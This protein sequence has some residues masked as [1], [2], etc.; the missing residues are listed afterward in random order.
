VTIPE[1]G[2]TEQEVAALVQLPDPELQVAFSS[3]LTGARELILMDALL[4]TVSELDIARLDQELKEF[5]PDRALSMLAGRG[6]RG[7]LMFA[8]PYVLAA[9]PHLLGYY[10]LLLGYSQKEFYTSRTGA[11]RFKGM[12]ERGQLSKVHER[13]LKDL[14]SALVHGAVWLLD[15]VGATPLSRERLDH[16][17]LL[18]L[19]PQLRGGSNVAKGIRAIDE[20]FSLIKEITKAASPIISAR[21]IEL[22]NDSKL[23]ILIEFAADPDIVVRGELSP[24]N[25]ENILAIEVKGGGDF[26]NIHNRIGEAEKC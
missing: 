7:E 5:V 16:L 1:D 19:G 6:L 4:K 12:E 14:C 2:L 17:T 10:R 9:N 23:K 18:T 20:V 22:I 25:F 24:G 15:G 3:A 26:S 8:T 11:G 21:R 13:D